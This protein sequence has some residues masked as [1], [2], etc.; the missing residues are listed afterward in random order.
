[1]PTQAIVPSTRGHGVYVVVAGKAQLKEVVIG[2]RTDDQVQILRGLTE[3]DVVAT[4]NL[5]R[6]RPGVEVSLVAA[7]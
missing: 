2:T 7:P 4:T 5:N 3:G 1:V 6:I